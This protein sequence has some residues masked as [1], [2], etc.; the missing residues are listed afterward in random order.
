MNHCD[1]KRIERKGRACFICR[2]CGDDVTLYLV[3]LYEAE[4]PIFQSLP[5]SGTQRPERERTA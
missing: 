2:D 1:H 3:F 5:T 4:T